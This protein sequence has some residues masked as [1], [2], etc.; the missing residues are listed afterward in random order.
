MIPLQPDPGWALPM[1]PKKARKG[2]PKGDS[3]SPWQILY[4]RMLETRCL[5]NGLES[6]IIGVSRE[7][8]WP[9]RRGGHLTFTTP[10]VL[11]TPGEPAASVFQGHVYDNIC[12][13]DLSI[14]GVFC[15]KYLILSLPP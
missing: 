1:A 9:V 10:L 3:S 12:L 14:F 13:G 4:A 5:S 8:A 7:P 2:V 15:R 6:C 11:L